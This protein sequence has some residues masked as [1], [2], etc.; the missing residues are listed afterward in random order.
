[1]HSR[2]KTQTEDRIYEPD[3]AISILVDCE[4]RCLL[5]PRDLAQIQFYHGYDSFQKDWS[6]FDMG[7]FG[8][9]AF[10]N[11][12]CSSCVLGIR[13]KTP[14]FWTWQT[15]NPCHRCAAGGCRDSQYVTSARAH[16]LCF[17][18]RKKRHGNRFLEKTYQ[19][20]L[21]SSASVS[22]YLLDEDLAHGNFCLGSESA[23]SSLRRVRLKPW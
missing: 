20:A 17:I 9:L 11:L 4:N 3:V 18:V 14:S 23:R 12:A 13:W 15:I 5:R 16:C 21:K 2:Q 8:F 7:S 22:H 6:Y 1:M 19:A 10:Y